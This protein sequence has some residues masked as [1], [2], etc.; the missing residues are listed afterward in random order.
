VGGVVAPPGEL[1]SVSGSLAVTFSFQSAVDVYGL[2]RYC[3]VYADQQEAPTLRVHPGDELLITLR[4]DLPHALGGV[5]HSH[6]PTGQPPCGDAGTRGPSSTNLHFHGLEIPPVCHQD[7]TLYTSVEPGGRDFEYRVKI[8][9]SESPGLY[10]YHP[11]PHGFTEPQ[12]LGGASGALIVEGIEQRSPRVAGLP[13]RVLVLRD[14]RVPQLGEDEEDAGPG[15]DL[16]INHVPVMYPLYRPAT[17]IAKPETREFWRVLNAAADT[18]FDIQLRYGASIQNLAAQDSKDAQ[19]MDLVAL[20]GVAVGS[21]SS[22]RTHILLAPGARAEFIVTTPGRGLAGQLVTLRYDTGPDGAVTPYRAI[23]N[24]AV[25]TE[26][27]PLATIPR[28]PQTTSPVAFQG[29]TQ[30]APARTRTLYFSE[31]REKPDDPA[32]RIKYF[33]TQQGATPKIFDMNFKQPDITVRQGIVEDWVVENRA[34]EAHTFHIHQLHFQVIARD[35]QRVDEAALR[36]TI[37]LPYWEGPGHPY[38]S[39]KL[40]MDFRNPD[41]VGLFVYHCHILDHEDGGMMGSIRVLP[42]RRSKPVKEPGLGR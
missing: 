25:S 42:N 30:F 38:P 3:Y 23:A 5:G 17:I 12:V 41:I 21:E 16:S 31:L 27:R 37:D 18:Y 36:D 39:V 2:T 28:R 11:H 14:Q 9:L 34:R 6:N 24:I 32:S 13:E 15:K 19:R 29:L 4:N 26:A 7:E 20:D 10:W 40:R 35:G 33:V 22:P 1:R 8:P